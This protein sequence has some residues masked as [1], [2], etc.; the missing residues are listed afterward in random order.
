MYQQFSEDHSEFESQD[1]RKAHNCGVI[2]GA[3]LYIRDDFKSVE[4]Q[5]W[6]QQN[7]ESI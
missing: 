4:K 1:S 5:T 2:S 7:L 3:L 6:L